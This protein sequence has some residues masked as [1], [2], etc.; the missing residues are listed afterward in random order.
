MIRPPW[1]EV[2]VF[3]RQRENEMGKKG[4]MEEIEAIK[5]LLGKLSGLAVASLARALRG[6]ATDKASAIQHVVDSLPAY[7]V[8]RLVEIRK[9]LSRTIAGSTGAEKFLFLE[10]IA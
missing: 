3:H 10:E 6:E 7:S 4:R 2:G 9:A 5:G 1:A 8:R